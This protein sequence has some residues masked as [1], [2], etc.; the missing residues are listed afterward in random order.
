V[1][2]SA[3]LFARTEGHLPAPETAHAIHGA[4]EEARR[5]KESGEAKT[6]V[7]GASGHGHFDLVSYQKYFAGELS[8]HEYPEELIR[9]AQA[10]LPVV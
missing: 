1:F 2:Q 8:D 9:K 10:S 5:C 4:V 6:I 7:F 3:V